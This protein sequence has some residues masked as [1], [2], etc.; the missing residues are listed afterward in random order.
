MIAMEN[1]ILWRNVLPPLSSLYTFGKKGL[2]IKIIANEKNLRILSTV[3]RSLVPELALI[4]TTFLPTLSIICRMANT[5]ENR[6]NEDLPL[7]VTYK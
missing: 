6:S 4:E 5:D 1:D 3:L 7:I 2:F